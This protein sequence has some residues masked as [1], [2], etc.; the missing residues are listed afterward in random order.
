MKDKSAGKEKCRGKT[1][2]EECCNSKNQ[3]EPGEGPC[4]EDTDCIGA[5]ICARRGKCPMAKYPSFDY[6]DRCCANIA[7]AIHG[8]WTVW[9]GTGCTQTCGLCMNRK[10]RLCEDPPP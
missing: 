6:E 2:E 9:S 8:Q 7:I 3:C 1:G 5:S 4:K 10:V